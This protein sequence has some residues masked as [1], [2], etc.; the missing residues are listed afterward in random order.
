ME[1]HYNNLRLLL[2]FKMI[3]TRNHLYYVIYLIFFFR[4]YSHRI[5]QKT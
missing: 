3:H 2:R 5:S 4:T 1:V